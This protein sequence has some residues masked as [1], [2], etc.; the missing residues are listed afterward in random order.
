MLFF[1][2]LVREVGTRKN[3]VEGMGVG[4]RKGEDEDTW[5]GKWVDI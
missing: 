4:I 2:A 3:R 1:G 5:L